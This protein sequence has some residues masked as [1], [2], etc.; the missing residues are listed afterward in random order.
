MTQL[1]DVHAN[2]SNILV[3]LEKKIINCT[4]TFQPKHTKYKKDKHYIVETY[5]LVGK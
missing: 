3:L 5:E 2:Y 4:Y 1:F